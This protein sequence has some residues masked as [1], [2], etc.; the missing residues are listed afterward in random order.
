VDVNSF[1]R[2]L[3]NQHAY[4]RWSL[5]AAA[6]LFVLPLLFGFWRRAGRKNENDQGLV[7]AITLTWTLVL[8]VYLGI[9]DTTLVILSVLLTTHVFYR[10]AKNFQFELTPVYKLILLLLYLVPWITQPVAQLTGVQLYTI[11]L[12]LFGCYQLGQRRR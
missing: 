1:F 8:N 11:I 5:V 4:L 7:W 10:R 2:L 9:Y 6:F 12:A 3:L